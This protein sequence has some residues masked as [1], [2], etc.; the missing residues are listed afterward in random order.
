MLPDVKMNGCS[1]GLK[2]A[3]LRPYTVRLAKQTRQAEAMANLIL[4]FILQEA[5]LGGDEEHFPS[6]PQLVMQGCKGIPNCP[7][8]SPFPVVAG[9]VNHIPAPV[10]EPRDCLDEDLLHMTL[11]MPYRA[12]RPAVALHDCGWQERRRC[13]TAGYPDNLCL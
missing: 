12:W 10:Q 2:L 6:Q 7:L 1:P 11:T 4:D 5:R 3:Q 8:P 13:S 9:C